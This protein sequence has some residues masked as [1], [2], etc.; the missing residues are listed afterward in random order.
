MK[1]EVSGKLRKHCPVCESSLFKLNL[2]T[3]NK[4]CQRCGYV[5]KKRTEGIYEKLRM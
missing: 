2:V 5:H 1:I 3:K 4:E